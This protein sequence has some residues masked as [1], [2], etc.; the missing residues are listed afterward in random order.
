VA[1][2]SSEQTSERIK[3]Q[4]NQAAEQGR[5][6]G[7][8]YPYGIDIARDE[9]GRPAKGATP[10]LVEH[11]AEVVR[12]MA[13]AVLEGRSL[14][15]IERELN[16]RGEPAPKGGRWHY[17]NIRK[18]LTAP[19]T[20]GRRGRNGTVVGELADWPPVLDADTWEAVKAV[21]AGR[22][23][24]RT[25]APHR[26]LLTNFVWA[27][28][29]GD[30]LQSARESASD[31]RRRAYSGPGAWVDAAALED[32]VE[33]IVKRATDTL[34]L[35]LVTTKRD[36]GPAAKIARLEQKL[37]RLILQHNRDEITDRQL[38]VGSA[39]LR[40]Q[41][42]AIRASLAADPAPTP[43]KVAALLGRPG[44]LRARWDGLDFET[45]RAVFTAL[46][47]RVEVGPSIVDGARVAL[48]DRVDVALTKLPA[49]P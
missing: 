40:A 29:T 23:K 42:D 22:T 13:Q 44:E 20:A 45:K 34:T 4:Q 17:P 49:R 28:S 33:E 16:G 31:N 12:E 26:Y 11:E 30:R 35:P 9:H 1:R 18:I 36:V 8:R 27:A 38:A 6:H 5:W 46:G 10:F 2:Q 32:L 7:G 21:L 39:D 14:L 15:S 48:T 24:H 37:D 47:L 25:R 43:G 3:D 19:A 41:I